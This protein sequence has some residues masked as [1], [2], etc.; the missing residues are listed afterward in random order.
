MTMLNSSWREIA[1]ADDRPGQADSR[2]ARA[3]VSSDSSIGRYA[4]LRGQSARTRT[5]CHSSQAGGT[6]AFDGDTGRRQ[7]RADG[8]WQQRARRR[9]VHGLRRVCSP[10]TFQEEGRGTVKLR[11]CFRGRLEHQA[12]EA[13]LTLG[14]ANVNG[15]LPSLGRIGRR[16]HRSRPARSRALSRTHR[17]PYV[18][19]RSSHRRCSSW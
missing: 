10:A 8:H 2:H 4:G 16:A 7:K 19:P 1:A 6:D 15:R 14:S 13:E 12:C 3:L 11:H 9:I 18:N 17:R 5:Q